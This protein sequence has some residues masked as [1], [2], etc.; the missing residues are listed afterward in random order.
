VIRAMLA[1]HGALIRGA[2]AF[3]LDTEDDIN[4]VAEIGSY[5]DIRDTVLACRPDITVLDL[6]L[7]PDPVARGSAELPALWALHQ[8]LAGCHLLVLAEARK[9]AA[10]GPMLGAQQPGL[11]FL[12]KDGPPE[13][14]VA[15]VRKV[16]DGEPMLDPDLVVSA[17]R[18]RSPLTPRETQVL[19]VAAEGV[20]VAEVADRLLLS[21]GTVRNHLSRV[22]GKTGAR[23][24]IEAV[25]IAQ[26]AG[27]I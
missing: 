13:R 14:L 5:E 4:V 23:T 20:P 26:D 6:D 7:L 2:I 24:R 18:T 27:W 16:A 25:R 11:G 17:L 19:S 22:I 1:H 8:A 15:A 10:L 3:V 9:A 12:A 21:P